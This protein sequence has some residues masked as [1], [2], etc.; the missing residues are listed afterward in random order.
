MISRNERIA[1]A[2]A[3]LLSSYAAWNLWVGAPEFAKMASEW[4]L[5]IPAY[6]EPFFRYHKA[7]VL[8]PALVITAWVLPQTRKHRGWICLGIGI[9]SML[10]QA[11]IWVPVFAAPAVTG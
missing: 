8:L 10:F 7:F 6:V 2:A 4:S 5:D 9:L 3:L 11:S 1:F